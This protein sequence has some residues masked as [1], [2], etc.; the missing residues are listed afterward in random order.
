MHRLPLLSLLVWIVAC[1]GEDNGTGPS[2]ANV[3]GSWSLSIANMSGGGAG[4]STSSPI[5]IS[6][7][8]STTTFT[9]SY[10]GGGV[11]T[12]TAPFGSFSAATG[13]GSVLNG[14]I[15]GNEVSFDLGSAN[16]HQVGTVTGSSMAGTATWAFESG[17]A[18]TLGTL[19]GSWTATRQ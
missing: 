12:C 19:T 1:G 16:F 5:Q 8:Q 17:S 6:L 3:N 9:G 2:F 4:C 15:S 10:G 14:Q 7:Q 13:S 18:S 11:L